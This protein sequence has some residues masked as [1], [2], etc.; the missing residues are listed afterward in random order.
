MMHGRLNMRSRSTVLKKSL[1]GS[2][3]LLGLLAAATILCTVA[4][5]PPAPGI[6]MPRTLSKRASFDL[7]CPEEQLVGVGLSSN[8]HGVSGCGKKVTYVCAKGAY[9]ICDTWIMNSADSSASSPPAS[10]ADP[11]APAGD[12]K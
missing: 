1:I 4:C 8:S 7:S 3:M 10:T 9:G 12:T 2:N 5:G 11:A 6:N